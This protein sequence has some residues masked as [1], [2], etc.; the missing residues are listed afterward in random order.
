MRLVVVLTAI[1][2]IGL[3]TIRIIQL[4]DIEPRMDQAFMVDWVQSIYESDHILPDRSS[5]QGWLA[6]L[7]ADQD[8]FLY[9]VVKPIYVANTTIFVV[10]SL[11]WFSLG[12]LFIG[13]S[14]SAQVVLSIIG[15]SLMLLCLAALP[16][17]GAGRNVAMLNE[18][19][20]IGI[21]A[22]AIAAASS[23]LHGFS[24]LGAH[25]VGVLTLIAAVL[26]SGRYLAVFKTG[27]NSFRDL[28]AVIVI[29]AIACYSFYTNVFLLPT[30]TFGLLLFQAPPKLSRRLPEAF[31]FSILTV[32]SMLPA[33]LLIALTALRPHAVAGAEDFVD[34]GRWVFEGGDQSF[35]LVI[36]D[37]FTSWFTR[38][39]EIF[40]A[41]GLTLAI[42]G[43]AVLSTR[44]RQPLPLG[45]VVMHLIV[46]TIMARFGAQGAQY[47]RTSVY[48][49][50]FLALGLAT[51][52]VW[53]AQW[54]VRQHKTQPIRAYGL[55]A[56]AI[57]GL[58]AHLATDLPRLSDLRKT[59][60]WG[61]YYSDQNIW[62]PLV[63]EIESTAQANAVI[64]PW[65]QSTAYMIRILRRRDPGNITV[66]RPFERLYE[67]YSRGTLQSYIRRRSLSLPAGATIYLLLPAKLT[68]QEAT[69]MAAHV[70][71][72]GKLLSCTRTSL[73]VSGRWPGPGALRTLY[74]GGL[75]LYR[76]DP[77]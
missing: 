74:G 36:A 59:P 54:T 23:F 55:A 17:Y 7:E 20:I 10:G 46:W 41:T 26:I 21:L 69:A 35:L 77:G 33:L 32:L 28:V 13:I 37:N 9:A 19:R 3:T 45:I 12:S 72:G 71:C 2:V 42:A 49:A 56:T 76:V 27:N 25:N 1:I 24:P 60:G 48:V 43:L 58:A 18:R 11:I 65:D 75:L 57:A 66:I 68:L 29:Q 44:Y 8:S 61:A 30:A 70:L 16:I 31:R 39:A 4:Q 51:L 47:T 6:A 63:R 73:S 52:V 5:D 53:M 22:L 50:P 67:Q 14:A 38:Q 40:S 62:R 64:F 34:L 15:H